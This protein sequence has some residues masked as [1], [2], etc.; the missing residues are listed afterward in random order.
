METRCADGERGAYRL[1]AARGS[2][3][4]SRSRR[5]SRRSWPRASTGSRRR[6]SACSRRAAVIGK[7][8]PFA[9]L[10]AI[11]DAAGGD[12]CAA[13]SRTLQAAEFLYEARL[14]PDLEYTFKHALTH[15]VA[16]GSAA[17]RPPAGAARP[18]R[19]QPSRASTRSA[20]PSTSSGSPI[21]R[22]V[23]RSGRR[24]AGIATRPGPRRPGASRTATR[25]RASSRRWPRWRISRA[26]RAGSGRPS[27]S[28][29]TS[30]MPSYP[31]APSPR[32]RGISTR[33]GRWPKL[34]AIGGGWRASP[35]T[36]RATA[37][38]SPTTTGR[39]VGRACRHPGRGDRGSGA[40]GHRALLSRARLPYAW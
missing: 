14:F 8:V 7:D 30:A 12:R 13:A 11:A 10:Q 35:S 1:T 31:S 38:G 17:P 3:R 28:G 21:M 29:S 4:P 26:I 23:A 32:R 34:S 20:S 24:P 2:S 19:R 18:D 36:R 33:P 27:I 16:Y 22:F 25:S 6:T 5:R 39:S 15:E 37:G 9:L 40:R